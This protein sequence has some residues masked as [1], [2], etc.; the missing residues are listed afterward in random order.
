MKRTQHRASNPPRGQTRVIEPR[1]LTEI[2]GGCGITIQIVG[3][4]PFEM[5]LQH[6]E[7]LVRL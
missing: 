2:L 7:T 5:R 3:P 4:T 6:N 1:R